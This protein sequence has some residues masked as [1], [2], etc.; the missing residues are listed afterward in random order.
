MIE[1]TERQGAA[2]IVYCHLAEWKTQ[3]ERR[4]HGFIGQAEFEGELRAHLTSSGGSLANPNKR[5]VSISISL[6]P[7]PDHSPVNLFFSVP[8]AAKLIEELRRAI[9]GYPAWLQSQRD[10]FEGR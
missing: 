1:I 8:V 9:E 10:H 2:A 5:E 6:Q 7:R 3:E 4:D